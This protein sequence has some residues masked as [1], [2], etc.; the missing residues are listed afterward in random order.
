MLPQLKVGWGVPA[1]RFHQRR[2]VGGE[3]RDMTSRIQP[4]LAAKRAA[5]LICI[6]LN[7]ART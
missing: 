5:R 1:Y 3:G 6:L 2:L 4:L 7:P